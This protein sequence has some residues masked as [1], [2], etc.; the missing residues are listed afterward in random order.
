ATDPINTFSKGMRQ[1]IGI[2]RAL[3]H[4]PP[5]L[6]LDEPTMGL[7]PATA[8]SIRE[9][10]RELKGDKTMILCT[11]YMEEADYLCDRV[12]ILNQGRILDVGTPRELKSKIKGD[13]ILEIGLVDPSRVDLNPIKIEGVKNIRLDGDRLEISLEDR[14]I[15]PAVIG[16]LG[17]NVYSVNTKETSLDDVFIE[18]VKGS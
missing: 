9:L 7:D 18:M 13:L 17:G 10:I 2:V 11:H 15:I 8:A 12:A 14:S 16:G 4:D 1:R 5:I 6:I 3:V